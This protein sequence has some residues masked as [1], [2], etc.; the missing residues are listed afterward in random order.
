MTTDFGRDTFCLNSLR[1]GRMATGPTLIGQRLYHCLITQRGALA[2]G[3]EE[4]NFGES[5]QDLIG[6]PSGRGTESQIRAKVRRA[7]GSDARILETKIEI[8]S[9]T[10]TTGAS[11]HAV[12]ISC[13]TAEGPFDLVVAIGSVTVEL[14]KLEVS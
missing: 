10:E 14:L 8:A 11:T 12:S 5:L 2:G 6:A 9:T 7:A 1:T 3:E 4:A 13:T